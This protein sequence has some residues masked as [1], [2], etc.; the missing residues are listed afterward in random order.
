ME[1]YSQFAEVYDRLMND[2]NYKGRTDYLLK[3]FEKHGKTPTLLLD[4]ACGT[5]GFSNQ[6]ALKGIEVIGVDMSEEM[7]SKARENSA[8]LNTDVLFLCQK[9]EELDLFGTVDG[10]ICCM[11]SINHITD[12]ETLKEAFK[13]VSLFLEK[14]CLFIF[15]ANTIYKHKEILGNNTFVIDEEDVYCVWQNSFDKE[16][17]LTDIALDFFVLNEE[18]DSY[19]RYCED[20]LEKAYSDTELE[21]ALK[22]AGLE[23][24]AVY[25]DMSENAPF[26]TT[27]R[28]IFVAK[29][30][31]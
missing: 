21:T 6:M 15:D 13:K 8:E 31:A 22:E 27:E 16:T 5:G 7:L 20:I 14:D 26:D 29:K 2:V 30:L 12:Y 18:D 19:Y 3:L 17:N 28:K 24:I 11:D 23:L 4:L 25:D 9:A 10:A 1:S